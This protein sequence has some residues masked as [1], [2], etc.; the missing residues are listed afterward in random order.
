MHQYGFGFLWVCFSCMIWMLSLNICHP[1]Q[2]EVASLRRLQASVGQVRVH[3]ICGNAQNFSS[4]LAQV[5]HHAVESHNFCWANKGE[6]KGVEE[7]NHIPQTID[8][9]WARIKW[10]MILIDFFWFCMVLVELIRLPTVQDLAW[11]LGFSCRLSSNA[12]IN[13]PWSH[14]QGRPPVVLARQL[15]VIP[16]SR[17]SIRVA[18]SWSLSTTQSWW[19]HL[20]LQ[21]PA[22]NWEQL[23]E[24]VAWQPLTTAQKAPIPIAAPSSQ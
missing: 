23:S 4:L 17:Q 3:R 5:I 2:L 9:C 21:H 1:A 12:H 14:K 22:Q 7:E 18:C 10:C 20:A 8:G 13:I 11:D 16:H 6:V 15:L 19:N 24:S